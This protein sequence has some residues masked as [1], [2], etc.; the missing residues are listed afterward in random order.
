MF[1]G[2]LVEFLVPNYIGKIITEFKENNFDGDEGVKELLLEWIM[3][4]V[5]SA[6][7][8]A[9]REAIFGITSQKIGLSIRQTLYSSIIKKDINF[10]DNIKTG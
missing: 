6:I 4:T 1:F 7:C 10:Y 3:F 9:I 2:S 8:T 5:F